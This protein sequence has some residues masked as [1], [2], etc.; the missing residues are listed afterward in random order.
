MWFNFQIHLFQSHA[1]GLSIFVPLL[2]KVAASRQLAYLQPSPLLTML[3]LP[4][5]NIGRNLFLLSCIHS[6]TFSIHYVC[7]LHQWRVSWASNYPRPPLLKHEHVIPWL[8]Q[9][10][11]IRQS[12]DHRA[13]SPQPNGMSVKNHGY[14]RSQ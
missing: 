9:K 6:G 13:H 2:Y 4:S 11:S 7:H 14:Q 1:C 3:E 12:E 8:D 10:I 5:L